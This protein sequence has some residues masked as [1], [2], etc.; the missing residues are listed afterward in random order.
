[1]HLNASITKIDNQDLFPDVK[2]VFSMS[3]LSDYSLHSFKNIEK[4][5]ETNCDWIS[6]FVMPY[7]SLY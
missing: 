6:C 1:M 5:F 7:N 4:K 3:C 2:F